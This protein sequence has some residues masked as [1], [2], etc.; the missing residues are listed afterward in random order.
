MVIILK[1]MFFFQFPIQI[2][3][4]VQRSS[5]PLIIFSNGNTASLPYGIEN[6]KTYESKC[7]LRDTD[8]IVDLSC[9]TFNATDYICYVVKNEGGYEVVSCSLR[10]ELGDLDRSNL[11]R[12]K[13]V[14]SDADD[15]YVVGQLVYKNSVYILCK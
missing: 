1:H 13:V 3:Q 10:V 11:H 6:R 5:S 7:L 15:V 8:K 4:I 2:L 12:E 9:W 14:R